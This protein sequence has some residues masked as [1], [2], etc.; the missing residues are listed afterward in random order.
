MNRVLRN[1]FRGVFTLALAASAAAQPLKF[2]VFSDTHVGAGT[3]AADLGMLVDAVNA[4]PSIRFVVVTGDVTEKGSDAE[5]RE[6]KAILGRLKVPF[7]ALP[8]NHDTHWAGYGGVGFVETFGADK[9]A[10]EADGF[11]FLGLNA[12]DMGH[13]APDDVLWLEEKVRRLPAD[14]EIFFFSHYP[15]DS[16]DNWA[17][18]HAIL[19]TRRTIVVAGHVHA[20]RQAEFH[21]LPVWTVRAGLAAKD[22]EPGFDVIT[23]DRDTIEIG[24]PET[25]QP[26]HLWGSYSRRGREIPPE[27]ALVPIPPAKAEILWRRELGTRLGVAP[28]FDG[29]RLYT[30]DHRGRVTC[31]DLK[32]KSLWV[33]EAKAPFISRP[34][35]QGKFL[36]AASADG[37]LFKLDTETGHAYVTADLGLRPTSPIV[38]FVDR[39]GKIARFWLGTSTGRL[40]CLNEFNLTPFWSSDAALGPI[41]S[42]PLLVG[43]TVLFGA[44]DGSAH[45]LDEA[46]GKTLWRWTENDNF[47]FSPAGCAPSSDGRAVFF[48]SP[49]GFVSAVDAMTGKTLWRVKAGAWESLGLSA[50]GRRI[51]VKSRLDEF[52]VLV[53]A[54]GSP[55]R[56]IAPAHG[57]GDL[58]PAEPIEWKGRILY[59]VRT[60]S[61]LSI[62]AAGRVETLLNLG[63]G[64]IHTLLDLGGGRFAAASVD[65]SLV[66]FRIPD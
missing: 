38:P 45:G 2:A 19:R 17:R 40:L 66:V 28:V 65:G 7:H 63:P 56:K 62:D 6:A 22:A 21:G 43:R 44:W 60:G 5:L 29:K 3:A 13:F 35:V 33:F 24:R 27:I 15:P 54:D 30:A 57:A 48:C 34:A 4:D 51:M 16:V 41:Q 55:L 47:Y 49:D 61:I 53:A 1:L 36:L 58:F 18:V 37:K 25:D 8:G 42:A 31:W 59:G 12:W 20:D 23:A 39:R 32:G 46:T 64:D 26:L 52:S 11:A 9:F 10:F 50:D 14:T